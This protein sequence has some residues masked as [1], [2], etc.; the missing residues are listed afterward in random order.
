MVFHA[1]YLTSFC[2]L[3]GEKILFSLKKKRTRYWSIGDSFCKAERYKIMNM[4]KIKILCTEFFKT[5]AWKEHQVWSLY[6][7]RDCPKL[8]K[9]FIYFRN[10]TQH[11]LPIMFQKNTR[12][13]L[14]RQTAA[15]PARTLFLNPSSSTR[16]M[17]HSRT[18]QPLEFTL[19]C[20]EFFPRAFRAA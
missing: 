15:C 17:F 1:N 2:S 12:K 13:L 3:V 10:L 14:N 6:Q 8:I 16:F 18:I 20:S 11:S 19:L 9:P 7:Y 5:Y 4:N